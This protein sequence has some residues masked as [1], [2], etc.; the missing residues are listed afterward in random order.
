MA[1]RI[2]IDG[3][4]GTTG[5]EIR[6]R[7]QDRSEIKLIALD[8]PRRKDASA[9]RDAL[10]EADIVILC[11]PD[12]A[13]REAIKLISNPGV[14]VIDPSTAHRVA[15]GWIFGF[16]E[17]EPKRREELRHALRV[18][19][20][21]C[22]STGFLA[23]ARPLL[24][25][26]IVPPNWPV[27]C[28]AVSGYSGG[29]RSMIAEFEDSSA[30]NYSKEVFRSYA[31][32]L[33]H[34]HVEEMR[35]HA[36]LTHRP[37]FAPSV[38]RFYRGMIVEI[39]LQLW[40]LPGNP[41][42]NDVHAALADSY[43]DEKL[44][45]VASLAEVEAKKTVDAEELKNTNRLKIYVFGNEGR[46]QARLVAVLDNLGKGAAGACVQN[47]NVMMGWPETAGLV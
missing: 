29:G 41:S 7:L 46:R 27:T 23:L 5:L 39:P 43:R 16:P 47:L 20:P 6:E 12:E 17:L 3:A 1:V 42:V 11:L 10:N 13:A 8:D 30:G 28:N 45:E 26:G 32:S 37:L 24:R 2:F 19:N 21:G 40:A 9:R 15:E 36:G 4:A 25:A 18:T 33:E 34:K 22:Y 38:S 31:L 14:R 44:I 35:V